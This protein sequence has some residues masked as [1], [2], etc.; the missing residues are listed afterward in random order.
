[1]I[2]EL[3]AG[4]RQR[5]IHVVMLAQYLPLHFVSTMQRLARKVGRLTLL[6]SEQMDACRDWAP[7]FSGLEVRVQRSLRVPVK[8]RHPLGFSEGGSVLIPYSTIPDLRALRPD[9]V[10]SCEVGPRTLQA[11]MLRSLGA[12]FKLI[13]QVRESENTAQS[14]GF[15]R[16]A[17]RRT[18]LPWV[19]DVFVNGMSGRQHVLSC[20]VAPGRISM[21]PSGTDTAVF[22][23]MQRRAADDTEL[24][25]LYVGQMIPR[26]GLFPF[27]RALAAAARFTGRRIHWML[28]GRGPEE[29][30]L[31]RTPWP[32][33][34]RLSFLGS[35]PYRELPALYARADAFVLPSLSDEW[36]MVVNEA[37]AS[38]LP[39]LGCTG[40]QAVEELVESG[41]SGWTYTPMDEAGRARAVQALLTA[42][43]AE[44]AA[45]GELAHA[46]AMI[47]SDEFTANAMVRG[48]EKVLGGASSALPL[49]R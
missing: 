13:V 35:Q 9:V 27:A 5:S 7:D 48:I 8:H 36:G 11:A 34:L 38:G 1:M 45:M 33:N 30:I 46:R 28:A 17:L 14:R 21:V 40:S 39:V 22:G 47:V 15:A 19:D 3:P 24:R 43:A 20:G 49:S 18:L 16:R 2:C 10:I 41:L 37:M 4:H 26:K 25:L 32:E 29:A 23:Q 6:L 31:R 12:K 42:S 44:L